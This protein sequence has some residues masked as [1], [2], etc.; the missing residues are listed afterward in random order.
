MMKVTVS[1]TDVRH[2]S[3]NAKVSGK[4]FNLAFQKVWLH[5][6]DRSGNLNPYPEKV[7][8]ILEKDEDDVALF[9]PVGE[10]ILH[11]SSIYVD[12]FG[13]LAVAPRLVAAKSAKAA[14]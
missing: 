1:S 5:T 9:Y 8:I 14:A 11:P 2:F 12:R 3:G 10:Y 4:P 6:Y 7:E 13:N